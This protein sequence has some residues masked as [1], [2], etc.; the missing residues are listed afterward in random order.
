M[1]HI[2]LSIPPISSSLLSSL[3]P[4]LLPPLLPPL[5]A[6]ADNTI[7]GYHIQVAENG[8]WSTNISVTGHDTTMYLYSTIKCGTVY[9]FRVAAVNDYS[10]GQY[11]YPVEQMCSE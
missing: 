5:K 1:T 3:P 8:S 4:S 11:S 7:H 6:S 2:V 10:Q 9:H